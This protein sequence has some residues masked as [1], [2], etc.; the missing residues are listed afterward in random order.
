MSLYEE[1]NYKL[2]VFD[3]MYQRKCKDNFCASMKQ[4]YVD[5]MVDE[6]SQRNYHCD[7]YPSSNQ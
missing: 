6:M 7:F 3:N 5:K 2:K 1:E 4:E